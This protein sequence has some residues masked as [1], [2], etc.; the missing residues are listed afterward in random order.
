MQK[1]PSIDMVERCLTE[2]YGLLVG[3]LQLIETNTRKGIFL[4]KGN[5]SDQNFFYFVSITVKNGVINGV[6]VEYRARK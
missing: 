2:K 1:Q 4:Y 5:P 6:K 3:D